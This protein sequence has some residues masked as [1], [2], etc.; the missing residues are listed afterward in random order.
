MTTAKENTI[1]YLT[2]FFILGIGVLI[3]GL[4]SWKLMLG[5]FFWTWGNNIE[6]GLKK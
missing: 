6:R 1:A 3:I 5:I 2:S 4:I